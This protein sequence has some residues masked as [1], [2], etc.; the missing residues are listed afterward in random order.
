MLF[1]LYE[2]CIVNRFFGYSI[3]YDEVG[4]PLTYRGNT[5]TWTFERRLASFGIIT[6]TYNEDG[7]R[8]LNSFRYRGY[9]YDTDTNVKKVL[10]IVGLSWRLIDYVIEH[11]YEI[12]VNSNDNRAWAFRTLWWYSS[13]I[14]YALWRYT[15]IPFWLYRLI[16][17]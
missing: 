14:K 5:L 8:S 1:Y 16:C 15:T 12:N 13:S 6:Y 9:Y 10:T 7:I 17:V 11:T 2:I 4:N 3:T